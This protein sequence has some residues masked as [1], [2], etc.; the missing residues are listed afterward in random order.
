MSDDRS[1]VVV[2]FQRVGS[3]V[4][5]QQ[6]LIFKDVND[7]QELLR[8]LTH[9]CPGVALIERRTDQDTGDDVDTLID[10]FGAVP[11]GVPSSPNWSMALQ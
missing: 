9:H 7:A 8:K 11:K 6:A 3:Y 2:P 4:G 5:A 10:A 1:F